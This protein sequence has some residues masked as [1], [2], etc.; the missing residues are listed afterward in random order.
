MYAG[1]NCN[2]IYQP[3][4]WSVNAD[5]PGDNE[6]DFQSIF[7]HELGHAL[8]FNHSTDPNAVMW[9][10]GPVG[11]VT[12]RILGDDDVRGLFNIYPYNVGYLSGYDVW[13]ADNGRTWNQNVIPPKEYSVWVV[14]GTAA[15]VNND[16]NSNVY[17]GALTRASPFGTAFPVGRFYVWD[18]SFQMGGDIASNAA[19]MAPGIACGSDRTWYGWVDAVTRNINYG[20]DVGGNFST[21]KLSVQSGVPPAAAEVHDEHGKAVGY[22]LAFMDPGTGYLR[23]M[24]SA[25]NLTFPSSTLQG[26]DNYNIRS[27]LPFGVACTSQPPECIVTYADGQFHNTPMTSVTLSVV[28]G[29]NPPVT[30]TVG[31]HPVVA[32]TSDSYGGAVQF[33]STGVVWMYAWRDR[34]NTVLVSDRVDGP[35]TRSSFAMHSAPTLSWANHYGTYAAFYAYADRYAQASPSPVPSSQQPSQEAL[36]P[37]LTPDSR[38]ACYESKSATARHV[39][40]LAVQRRSGCRVD[41]DCVLVD[42]SLTCQDGCPAAILTSARDEYHAAVSEAESTPVRLV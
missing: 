19:A 2:G 13:T 16:A 35:L 8:G 23:T 29:S 34:T 3:F 18:G 31:P 11:A 4:N 38:K 7:L 5:Y 28:P 32:R 6:I 17:Q 15:C 41:S 12:K 39:S 25:D 26:F 30:V 27:F 10:F 37:A 20:W 22:L 21:Y 33:D 24:V 36:N 14:G 9:A 1:T 42:T 40:N